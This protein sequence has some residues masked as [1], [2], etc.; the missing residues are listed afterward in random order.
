MCIFQAFFYSSTYFL[1]G[2]IFRFGFEYR[3]MVFQRSIGR[4]L[5]IEIGIK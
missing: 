3:I 5:C 1:K 2:S 4:K